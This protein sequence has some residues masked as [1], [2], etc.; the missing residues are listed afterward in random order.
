MRR[1]SAALLALSV[2]LFVVGIRSLSIS[3]DDSRD[4]FD[5][6]VPMSITHEQFYIAPPRTPSKPPPKYFSEPAIRRK[7]QWIGLHYDKKTF[8]GELSDEDRATGIRHMLAAWF[9]FNSD[10]NIQSWI[11][12][13]TLLGWYWNGDPLPWDVDVDVQMFVRTMQEVAHKFNYTTYTYMDDDNKPHKYL[14]DI[15]PYFIYRSRGNG[16]NVIDGRFIDTDNGLYIDLTALAEADP[17]RH[18][19]IVSCKNN[20]KYLIDDIVPLRQTLFINKTTY[21]PY[22]FEK[23]LQKEYSR[24]ALTNGRFQGYVFSIQDQKW[25][26][27]QDFAALKRPQ[28]DIAHGHVFRPDNRKMRIATADDFKPQDIPESPAPD[29]D[30]T[31]VKIRAAEAAIGRIGMKDNIQI[32]KE[33]KSDMPP[34]FLVGAAGRKSGRR[35][36]DISSAASAEGQ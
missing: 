9:A 27:A 1:R 36:R 29:D 4:D 13:G 33:N 2:I 11:A 31:A 5:G 14:I 19:N 35:R 15:N 3:L 21:V 32:V 18:P 20:H 25:L 7:K 34:R 30:T 24:R 12:H 10:N 22:E 6:I 23:I 17:I 16:M 26:R 28:S 8:K